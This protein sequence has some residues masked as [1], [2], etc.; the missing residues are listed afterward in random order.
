M[1]LPLESFSNDPSG[2]FYDLF[3]FSEFYEY[4]KINWYYFILIVGIL[5]CL[6]MLNNT[7]IYSIH[8]GF[9]QPKSV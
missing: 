1:S 5:I 9:K 8:K 4:Y 3:Y 2:D 7:G 6:I